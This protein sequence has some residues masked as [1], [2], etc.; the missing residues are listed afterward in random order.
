MSYHN[1]IEVIREEEK[2]LYRIMKEVER[3]G[4]SLV[5]LKAHPELSSATRQLGIRAKAADLQKRG[6][7]EPI[8]QT[9]QYE[10]ENIRLIRKS[11]DT[12]VVEEKGNKKSFFIFKK[13]KS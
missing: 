3:D 11:K 2:R 9:N 13:K 10:E 5:D 8:W 7:L 12:E 4:E 1:F 6:F